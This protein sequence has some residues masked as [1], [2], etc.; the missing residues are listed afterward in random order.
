MRFRLARHPILWFLGLLGASI[1]PWFGG[2]YSSYLL[3]SILVYVLVALSLNILIGFGGQVSI[4]HAGFWALGAYGSAL[5]VTK[6]SSPFLVGVL[7]G[8]LIA[9][10]AG[11]IVA[12]PALRV[13]G[14]YLAIA[15]LGFAMVIQQ[16]LY[17]WESLTGG[18]QGLFVPRPALLGFS[19]ETD[20]QYYVF[21][22]FL[23]AGFAWLTES[24][25]R[26]RTGRGLIAFK[27]SP[28]AAQCAGVNRTRY[29]VIAFTLSAFFTGVSGALY[30]HLLGYLSTE[31][32]SLMASLSFLTMTVIGGLGT[33]SGAFLGASYLTLSP[34]IFRRFKDAQMVVYGLTLVLCLMFVPGGLASLLQ[35]LRKRWWS[36][37]KKELEIRGQRDLSDCGRAGQWTRRDSG[38]SSK[39][40]IQRDVILEVRQLRKSFAGLRA[41]DGVSFQIGRASI[42]GLIGPNGAGKTTLLN[43]LSRVYA[44]DGGQIVFDHREILAVPIH[45]MAG[46]GMCRTFQNLELFKDLSVLENVLIGCHPHYSSHIVS[47]VCSLPRARRAMDGAIAESMS[48]LDLLGL[49]HCATATVGALPYGTQK[50]VELARALAGRPKLLLLDEPAAG[51]NPEESQQVAKTIRRLRDEFGITV[52]LV[53][54]DMSLVMQNCERLIV[55]DHGQKICEG[56]P[57]EVRSDP[58]VI[59]A[60]LGQEHSSDA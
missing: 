30:A 31:T 37:D 12:L 38:G 15:T 22:V 32:F 46:L 35:P 19:L 20:L 56:A 28:I 24:F 49:T 5:L 39:G 14:H 58:R 26:C 7:V 54:H 45:E 18:R 29:L 44:V 40:D 27:M 52:L 60:Y 25:R 53:E 9:A 36:S 43:C 48:I 47:E 3:C 57:D 11:I 59:E 10:A 33:I 1:L 34:E 6:L 8:G 17:E 4:G 55:L 13:Q 16:V 2:H 41:V 42:V 23:V 50:T 21:L 51:M